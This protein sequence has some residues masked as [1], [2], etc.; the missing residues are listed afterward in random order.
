MAENLSRRSDV[1]SKLEL[2]GCRRCAVAA[3]QAEEAST[4]TDVA[5]E[6]IPY[7]YYN[8]TFAREQE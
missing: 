3:L 2:P 4:P 8:L 1:L 6:L 5:P 7:L